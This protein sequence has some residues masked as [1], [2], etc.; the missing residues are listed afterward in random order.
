MITLTP[1]WLL[2]KES[3][4]AI[5]IM[6]FV[7]APISNN[8]PKY[9]LLASP[10]TWLFWKIPTHGQ[11][12]IA[13]LQAEATQQLRAMP[14]HS[15]QP[16]A[17]APFV[18]PARDPSILQPISETKPSTA[19][20]TRVGRYHC[21]HQKRH[22]N[23]CLTTEAVSF[24][25][26]LTANEKWRLRYDELKSMQKIVGSSTISSGEDLLFV[27][28]NDAKCQVSGLKLRDEV[29]TQIIGYSG[30]QWQITE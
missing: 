10:L 25:M 27:D 20:A 1:V 19:E 2:V 11:W 23:L 9:R 30:V 13:R 12:A 18:G 8:F 26:H 15:D 4:F 6:F 3:F 17:N 14:N 5:G 21:I 22:G 28:M 7:L 29:F 24:E 16:P